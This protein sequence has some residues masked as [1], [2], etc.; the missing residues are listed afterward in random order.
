MKKPAWY[1]MTY[2]S[3]F[4]GW[5][6]HMQGQTYGLYCG[7]CMELRIGDRPVPCRLELDRDWY[8]IMREATFYL[9]KKEFYQIQFV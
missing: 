7:E 9:R 1:K 5:V 4:G 6:V 3:E 2:D 8:V